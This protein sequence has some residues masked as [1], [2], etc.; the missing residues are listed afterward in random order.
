MDRLSGDD[1]YQLFTLV[2]DEKRLYR[3]SPERICTAGLL[4]GVFD[5]PYY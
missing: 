3:Q 1:V 5:V 4:C 2:D